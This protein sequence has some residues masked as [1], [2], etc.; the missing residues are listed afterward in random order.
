MR[1]NRIITVVFVF[2]LL[3]AGSFLLIHAHA[4]SVSINFLNVNSGEVVDLAI[5][6]SFTL[7]AEVRADTPFISALMLSDEQFPGRGV[8]LN[9]ND[10]VTQSDQALLRLTARGKGSTADLPGGTAPVS[11]VVG[12]RYP[13]GIV[14]SERVDFFIRVP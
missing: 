4:A 12:V 7:E 1:I 3:F 13:G 10:I 8:F 6:E 2:V 5:G 9:G 14:F 11:L